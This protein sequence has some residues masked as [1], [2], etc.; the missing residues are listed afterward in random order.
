MVET[1]RRVLIDPTDSSLM[2]NMKQSTSVPTKTWQVVV[3]P[4]GSNI[5]ND[6][7]RD[8]ITPVY[9]TLTDTYTFSYLWVTTWVIIM[10]YTNSSKATLL[11]VTK[12]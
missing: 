8:L 3:N 7:K 9:A 6:I 1:V 10:T 5:F 4:D 2:A 12:T 11:S